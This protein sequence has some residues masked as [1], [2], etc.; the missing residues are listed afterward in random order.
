MYVLCI[1]HYE[2]NASPVSRGIAANYKFQQEKMYLGMQINGRRQQISPHLS[3]V[4]IE[5]C[6]LAFCNLTKGLSFSCKE[7]P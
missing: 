6:G 1:T 5:N 7:R 4:L 2:T 3:H